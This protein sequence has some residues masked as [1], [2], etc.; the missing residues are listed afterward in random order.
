MSF[1]F[2]LNL[3]WNQTSIY[4]NVSDPENVIQWHDSLNYSADCNFRV[5]SERL[6]PEQWRCVSCSPVWID[7]DVCASALMFCSWFRKCGS[8]R[9]S[10]KFRWISSI[11]W[12]S[13][14]WV[15][16]FLQQSAGLLLRE[17]VWWGNHSC[18]RWRIRVS[19][20]SHVRRNTVILMWICVK[21]THFHYVF[22][23][24]HAS[25]QNIERNKT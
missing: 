25:L 21:S 7:A 4:F 8:L 20:C 22:R 10:S 14:L 6:F 11:W 1:T 23:S 18:Q 12:V 5:L 19:V 17:G 2:S 3:F 16:P 24:K 13:R 9:Q 15:R